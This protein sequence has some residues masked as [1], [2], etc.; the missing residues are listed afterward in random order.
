M[1]VGTIV[2]QI[3]KTIYHSIFYLLGIVLYTGDKSKK[4]LQNIDTYKD[5]TSKL[6][7]S[8]GFLLF[9][10]T[11]IIELIFNYLLS[12]EFTSF[13]IWVVLYFLV[14]AIFFVGFRLFITGYDHNR[15]KFI[16]LLT[17]SVGIVSGIS[18]LISTIVMF[19]FIGSILLLSGIAEYHYHYGDTIKSYL[20]Q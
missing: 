5:K 18:L 4:E 7:M 10:V 2:K 19:M 3:F 14:Y 12:S 6:I 13:F 15:S 1:S 20:N 8:I 17:A 16:N 11:G 9:I